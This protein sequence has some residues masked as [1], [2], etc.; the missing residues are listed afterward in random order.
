MRWREGNTTTQTWDSDLKVWVDINTVATVVG[1]N[2]LI[3]GCFDIWQ[4]A[5][6][7]Q[8]DTS[9]LEYVAADRWRFRR[10]GN[11]TGMRIARYASQ[12]PAGVRYGALVDRVTN[13]ANTD[14]ML[15]GYQMA[16]E[17]AYPLQGQAVT[18]TLGVRVGSQFSA[19]NVTLAIASGTGED[20]IISLSSLVFPTGN[21]A[22]VSDSTLFDVGNSS[23]TQ[24]ASVTFTVPVDAT[25]LAFR[26][27]WAP[28]GVYNTSG[29]DGIIIFYAKLETGVSAT[30]FVTQGSSLG[31]EMALCQRYGQTRST[32]TV[33]EDDLRPSM[34]DTPAITG[35]GP[36]FYDAEIPV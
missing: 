27:T 12:Q 22:L 23:E 28:E 6:N 29:Q 11:A 5:T 17:D 15:A 18:L 31:A 25:E 7:V 3:N 21:V 32:N 13:D 16:T 33:D 30:P 2:K 24:V 8:D 26:L 14:N 4:R 36:Y 35:A 9:G 10:N 19:P 34:R 20:E 1:A